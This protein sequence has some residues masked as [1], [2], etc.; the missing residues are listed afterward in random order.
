MK[1]KSTELALR[2]ADVVIRPVCDEDF[3][4]LYALEVASFST[5][6]LSRRR[7]RHW[8]AARNREFF[9]AANNQGELF[10]YALVL[11]HKGTRLARLYSIAIAESARGLGI[12]RRLMQAV[13]TAAANR[14]RLYM[15]LEVAPDNHSAIALYQSLGYITFGIYH[16]YYEDHRDALRMQKRIR[17]APELSTRMVPWYKQTTDFTC[18]PA[19]MMMAMAALD[20]KLKLT[21]E[22]EL[23]L[24]REATT[25]FMT[26]GHG[27]SHPIGLALAAK[28]RGFKSQVYINKPG[29]LFVES[30]RGNEKKHIVSVVHNQYLHKANKARIPVKFEEITQANIGKWIKRGAM[31]VILISTYRMDNKRAPHWVT[32]TAIDDQCLY[33]HDPDPTEGVQTPLDCQYIP[34]AREDFSKMSVFG[35]ERIRTA[36]VIEKESR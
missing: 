6:R 1:K 24:W 12:G 7:F 16:D 17:F 8:I 28:A 36:V 29:P 9:V 19:S 20:P 26:A 30:V 5:D 33:L 11:I 14:G 15:R 23:D 3:E 18:G 13:E 21:Q 31:V 2:H 22:L 32:V 10:G 4:A 25:I 35:R 27:G 34:I